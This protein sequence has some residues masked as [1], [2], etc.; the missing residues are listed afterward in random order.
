MRGRQVNFC[1][2]YIS[3]GEQKFTQSDEADEVL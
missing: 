1:E 2:S 3:Y